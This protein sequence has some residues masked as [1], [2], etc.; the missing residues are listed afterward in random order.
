MST[1]ADHSNQEFALGV[2][3]CWK[4]STITTIGDEKNGINFPV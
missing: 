3:T 4:I 2:G 1:V